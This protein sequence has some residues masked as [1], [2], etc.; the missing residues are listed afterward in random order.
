MI[1]VH[2]TITNNNNNKNKNKDYCESAD[3]E[4]KPLIQQLFPLN[5]CVVLILELSILYQRKY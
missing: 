4:S 2:V 1:L 5:L 3:R